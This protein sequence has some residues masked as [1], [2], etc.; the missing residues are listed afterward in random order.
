MVFWCGNVW[1]D[2]GPFIVLKSKDDAIARV[3]LTDDPH[4]DS[5]KLADIV[6]PVATPVLGSSG[7][8]AFFKVVAWV[9]Y[10]NDIFRRTFAVR[11]DG[12]I[13]MTKDEPMVSAQ[14]KKKAYP[15]YR[16][17]ECVISPRLALLPQ[18][19]SELSKKLKEESGQSLI[20]NRVLTGHLTQETLHVRN[21]RRCRFRGRVN[22]QHLV[23]GHGLSFESCVFENGLDLSGARLKGTLSMTR[24]LITGRHHPLADTTPLLSLD[25]L[26]AD[27]LRIRGLW[28]TG[29]LHAR[30]R[31]HG[32]VQLFHVSTLGG[33]DFK[34]CVIEQSMA[35]EDVQAC[36]NVNTSTSIELYGAVIKY[37]SVVFQDVTLTGDLSAGFLRVGTGFF[38]ESS[39]PRGNTIKGSIELGGAKLPKLLRIGNTCVGKSIQAKSV[40]TGEVQILGGRLEDF[41]ASRGLTVAEIIR[42]L[43]ESFKASPDLTV[44]EIIRRLQESF[45]VSP[46]LTVAEIIRRLR[47]SFKASPDPTVA[48]IIRR[49]EE[50]KTTP[51]PTVE[52]ID[53]R[54]KE[55]KASHIGEVINLTDAKIQHDVTLVDLEVGKP[56][57]EDTS[58]YASLQLRNAKVG[59]S[60]RLFLKADD[61]KAQRWLHPKAKG[62]FVG[63]WQYDLDLRN[64]TICGD[65]DLSGVHCPMGGIRLEE[66]EIQRDLHVSITESGSVGRATAMHLAMTG[67]KCLGAAD[68]TGLD[69]YK[70]QETVLLVED[71]A[72]VRAETR[73]DLQDAGYTVVDAADG[74]TAVA[75][76]REH[77]GGI[78]LLVAD[79]EMPGMTRRDLAE[80][81]LGMEVLYT[82]S[83]TRRAIHPDC[84]LNADEDFL[85]K[86]FKPGTLVQKV[87][88]ALQSGRAVIADRATFANKLIVAKSEHLLDTSATIP[89]RLDLSGSTIGELAVSY[90][91]FGPSDFEAD[92]SNLNVD[93]KKELDDSLNRAQVDKL[94][95]FKKKPAKNERKSQ[96]PQPIDLR[97][98]E[99]KWWEFR[100]GDKSESDDADDYLKLLEGDHHKQRH[101]FSSIEQNL[102]NRGLD[103]AA[104]KVH[105]AMRK[106]LR[107]ESTTAFGRWLKNRARSVRNLLTIF[108]RWLKNRGP[109]VGD[110]FTPFGRW[111]KNRGRSVWDSLNR[112][113][114]VWDLFTDSTTSPWRLICIVLIW[115]AFSAFG[116]FSNR[117]NIGPSEAGLT[118]HREWRTYRVPSHAEWDWWSGVWMA[119]RFHV[120]VAVLTAQSAWAPAHGRDLTVSIPF[121]PKRWGISPEDYANLVL[122]LHCLFWPVILVLWSRKFFMRLGK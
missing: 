92:D 122:G 71:S 111:L 106:W 22:L 118:A 32:A 4:F 46:D 77:K 59:G 30:V 109:S 10:G 15:S 104:D 43:Q 16:P 58:S 36:K 50:L 7:K 120:P 11:P 55:R 97:F 86:P 94:S 103:G 76:A 98:S 42:R 102:F 64:A 49:L 61:A 117:S 18:E 72:P 95:V 89:G 54:L 67:V 48:E 56:P 70:D 96:Y 105:E 47:E 87:R 53:R 100:Q 84:V 41:K 73:R 5:A 19:A 33:I 51:D 28:S 45:K 9:L 66:A 52:E 23:S 12:W 44:A 119:A 26:F 13:I 114:S 107:G 20:K 39:A 93:Q 65:V 29:S 57:G 112:F 81:G 116:V 113:R 40:A 62:N 3:D 17:L 75:R 60:V 108:R 25:N 99:I 35:F 90:R 21:F 38:L 1:D 37:N 34:Q 78:D 24:C 82:S 69:L 68:I 31:I 80:A 27:G 101:T 83:K 121:L 14:V 79:V 6:M 91:S 110:L 63:K 115:T 85:Q 74:P 88:A 2:K 8:P